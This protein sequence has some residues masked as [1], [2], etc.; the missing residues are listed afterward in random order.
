MGCVEH[1]KKEFLHAGYKPIE[2]EEDGPNK[3][4]QENVLELLEVFAKQGHSGSS[5]NYAVSCFSK[6]ALQKPLTSIKC[7][8][9]E[10]NDVAGGSEDDNIFQNNRLSSVFKVGKDGKPYYLDAIVW[11]GPEEYDTFTGNVEKVCS[12]QYIKLP[13]TPKTFYIDATRELYD[14][15]KHKGREDDV[16]SCGDGDYV[17]SIKDREQLKEVFEY[18]DEFKYIP[19]PKPTK[20]EMEEF[21]KEQSKQ[22]DAPDSC[23]DSCCNGG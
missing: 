12:R 2:E 16:V 15:E 11:Q 1:A 10:W 7:T 22:S 8:D 18:Y 14:K 19:R 23:N 9:D 13:F 17:Y 4:I 21:C 5:A 3:W 20:E 6:L